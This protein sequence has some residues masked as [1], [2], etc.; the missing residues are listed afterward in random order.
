MPAEDDVAALAKLL[1][2]LD[3]EVQNPNAF[4]VPL[5]GIDWELTI[6]GARAITGRAELSK[7][8]PAKPPRINLSVG[9]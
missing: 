3:L 4:G 1:G 8:I 6:G 9:L 5:S 2:E 7:T